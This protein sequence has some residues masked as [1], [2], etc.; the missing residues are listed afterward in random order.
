MYS[1]VPCNY[2][3]SDGS[4]IQGHMIEHSESDGKALLWVNRFLHQL[5]MRSRNTAKQYAYRLCLFFNYLEGMGK[6][7]DEATDEDIISFLNSFLYDPS[8][9]TPIQLKRSPRAI[10]AYYTPI[11]GLYIYLYESKRPVMGG[12]I[13]V[14]TKE[15]P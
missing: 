11:R 15:K 7:Y 2:I 9:V 1:A 10:E 5:A 12:I 4:E 8:S 13:T 6:T 3:L 14:F